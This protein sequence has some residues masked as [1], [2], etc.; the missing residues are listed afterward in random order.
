MRD[1][2]SKCQKMGGS[3]PLALGHAVAVEDYILT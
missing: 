3:A 1:I 2:K